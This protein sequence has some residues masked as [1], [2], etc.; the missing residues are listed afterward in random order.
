MAKNSKKCENLLL[1]SSPG[2]IIALMYQSAFP[3]KGAKLDWVITVD[4]DL[5]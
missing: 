2:F 5:I 1:I 3:V 4:K